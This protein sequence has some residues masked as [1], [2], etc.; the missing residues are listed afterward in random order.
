M[1]MIPQA[2]WNE[3]LNPGQSPTLLKAYFSKDGY[4]IDHEK[5][6]GSMA[7]YHWKTVALLSTVEFFT[8]VFQN[9][10]TNIG[11][12]S[13]VRPASEHM[14]IWGVRIESAVEAQANASPDFTPGSIDAWGKNCTLTIY[15]NGTVQLKDYDLS[16]ALE[17]LTTRENGVI[18]LAI[19]FTWAGQEELTATLKNKQGNAGAADTYYKIVLI[20]AGAFS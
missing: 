5:T 6:Y 3:L 11:N 7:L 8:G 9:A 20:G 15:A 16:E 2:A 17:N 1:Q 19:P 4:P 13:W 10:Q 14:M 12:N 18:P